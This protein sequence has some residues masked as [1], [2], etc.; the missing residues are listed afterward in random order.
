LSDRKSREWNSSA[1][2]R[3]SGP[4]LEWGKRVV[5]RLE[6]RGGETLLDAGCGTGRITEE[7]LQRLPNGR[8]VGVDLSH[9]MLRRA[10]SY[11]GPGFGKRI[12]FIVADL[13]KLPFE[14]AFDVIFST[15]A[16]HWV[17]DHDKLFRSLYCALRPGGCMEAQCGGGPNLQC[18]R[19][20]VSALSASLPYAVFLANYRDGWVFSDAETAARQLESAGFIEVKTW[21]EPAPTS[22]PDAQQ[23]C[24]F[25]AN[26]VLHRRLKRLPQP[27]L[28]QEFLEEL[29]RQAAAD[30]PPF[31]LDYWRLNLSARKALT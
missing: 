5:A 14:A 1:Y 29:A 28:R 2:H 23:Y 12:S 31:E 21:L 19:S 30:D 17:P 15:A 10:D 13:Q 3:V 22:F 6:L 7:L 24:E 9:N 11:L 16:F 18:L 8:I 25:I 27:S 4:Q 26:V 20:R